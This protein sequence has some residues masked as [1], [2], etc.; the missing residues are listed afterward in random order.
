MAD[1]AIVVTDTGMIPGTNG[2]LNAL[3]YYCNDIDF[4]Y[5][6]L[7]RWVEPYLEGWQ[8]A[9]PYF[10]PIKIADL[11]ADGYPKHPRAGENVWYCK[12]Y[13]Y[14][15]AVR[16]L[17]EYEAVSV[18]DADMQITNN[19]MIW[20][21]IAAET[22]RLLLPNNDY[23]GQE[24]D[25][26]NIEAIRGAASP[27]LHNMPNF[28]DPEK[29]GWIMEQIPVESLAET[30]GDMSSLSRILIKTG[31]I[32]RI[33]PLPNLFWIQS[34]FYSVKLV[35][36]II[37]GKWFLCHN[38]MGDRI[39]SFHRRWWFESICRK[40]IGMPKEP[41]AKEFAKNNVRLFW[42]FT[43]HFNLSL[44][45]KIKWDEKKWGGYPSEYT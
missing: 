32:N 37:N 42:E 20:F 40:K 26:H 5:L 44:K 33:M 21:E 43:R 28:F 15:F 19:I 34:N 16:E 10:H 11:Q 17:K 38:K 3:D 23:S 24:Y 22:G 14:L 25:Q 7:G 18:F 30:L 8:K 9:F 2:M 41:V 29:F 13:R 6:H 36:R 45:H 12:M 27:P 1:F 4:Y 39:N 35:K 31:E